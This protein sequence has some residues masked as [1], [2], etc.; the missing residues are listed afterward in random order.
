MNDLRSSIVSPQKRSVVFKG[1]NGQVV[2]GIKI[3]SASLEG[4]MIALHGWCTPNCKLELWNGCEKIEAK[5][6]HSSR[7][8]VARRLKIQEPHPGFGFNISGRRSA[9]TP[10]EVELRVE[11]LSEKSNAESQIYR[12]AIEF[13]DVTASYDLRQNVVG[14]LESA[15]VCPET[16][17]MVVVGWSA[18][19]GDCDIWIEGSAGKDFSIDN[20]YRYLRQDVLNTHGPAF[21]QSC[22]DAGFLLHLPGAGINRSIRLMA[23]DGKTDL[24]LS[25]VA[26]GMLAVD[27]AAA[28]QWLFS[29]KTPEHDLPQRMAKVDQPV[30]RPL[31][32]KRQLG[33]ADLPLLHRE[34][35]GKPA[36]PK[37]SLIIPLFGRLDFVEHQLIEFCRDPWL[38]KHA[39]IIYVID[40]ARLL[41]NMITKSEQWYRL[42]RVPFQ[43]VWGAVNR[44]YSG[45]NNLGASLAQSDT[46]VF[47]NS[48]L[49]PRE[50]G[51]LQVLVSQMG[52]NEKIGALC[53]RLLYPD[54]SIQHA[55]IQF[56]RREELGIWI[57]HHPHMGSPVEADPCKGL[58]K[59]Q[60]VTGACMVVRKKAFDA[61]DGWDTGYLIG[62]FE[63]TDLCF[64][65]QSKGYWTM[66][67]PAVQLT[68]LERQSFR[69][70]GP[71]DFRQQV[72]IFNAIRHQQRWGDEL[73][74]ASKE[75]EVAI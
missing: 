5:L 28:A 25:E 52:S 68:H 29:L 67:L 35:G 59:V 20:A 43:W 14:F 58:T 69:N 57:N 16:G 73:L 51:W 30:L 22:H 55:G 45:A 21:G 10:L 9:Q 50:P 24:T 8:D 60:A 38:L 13:G 7:P 54:G 61:V 66:Y 62:D 32:E 12:Y 64:K 74:S 63:D 48:D 47:F 65:I 6:R 71:G 36:N 42:Y 39:E 31:I 4:R 26:V 1:R 41:E 2:A 23:S 34:L 56:V 72:V 15:A 3:D 75:K 49:F 70:I 53:P 11:V 17:D 27:P 18:K 40:D 44:G 46:L 19:R 33:W 37:A